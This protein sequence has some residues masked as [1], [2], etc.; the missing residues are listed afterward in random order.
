MREAFGVLTIGLLIVAAI[1]SETVLSVSDSPAL[2]AHLLAAAMVALAAVV[3]VSLISERRTTRSIDKLLAAAHEMQTD[4]SKRTH[5]RGPENIARLGAALDELA[6]ELEHSMHEISRGRDQLEAMLEAMQEGVLVTREDGTITVANWAL[7]RMLLS[8]EVIGR[9]PIE[10]ARNAGLHELLEEARQSKKPL[11]REL[12]FGTLQRRRVRVQVSP[13][14][15]EQERGALVAVFSDVTELR[16][17][18]SMRRD[19]VANVSHE[20]RTPVASVRAASETLQSMSEP[21]PEMTHELVDIIDRN[22]LRLHRLVEDLLDLSRIEAKEL[23]LQIRSLDME[24]EIEKVTDALRPN[25][26]KKDIQL[27]VEVPRPLSLLSD[28]RA[29]EQILTNL[30]ENAIKYCPIGSKV[31]VAAEKREER[32]LISVMDNGPGIDAAH[33]PRLFE[34]FY[35]VDAGRSRALG[36]TGLGLAIVKHLSE[37]LGGQASVES[38]PGKGSTF[39]ISLPAHRAPAEASKS[40]A[41]KIGVPAAV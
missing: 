14:V 30:I 41:E 33:L 27:V 8:G 7:R 34:R 3:L 38:V 39:C 21:D 5:L 18:E 32:V 19:F 40:G 31:R 29:L 12:S 11:S 4:L 22:A 2:S 6:A 24:S 26:A 15:R 17:L 20:L 9:R 36:G 37:A 13:I 16:R 35:R 1:V 25:A 10:I 28:A 23:H